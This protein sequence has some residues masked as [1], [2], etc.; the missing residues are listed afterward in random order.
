MLSIEDGNDYHLILNRVHCIHF[1]LAIIAWLEAHPNTVCAEDTKVVGGSRSQIRYETGETMIEGWLLLPSFKCCWIS[2]S[3]YHWPSCCTL[4]EQANVETKTLQRIQ[5]KWK[6][7]YINI[8]NAII[9]T[10]I[11]LYG[12]GANSHLAVCFSSTL[13]EITGAPPSDIGTSI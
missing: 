11:A 13:Y 12:D 4:A 1:Y 5:Q 9:I 3:L 7:Q 2:H 8:I 6:S 10:I